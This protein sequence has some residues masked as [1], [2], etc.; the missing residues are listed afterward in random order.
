MNPDFKRSAQMP[1]IGDNQENRNSSLSGNLVEN[2]LSQ[3]QK[4]TGRLSRFFNV[5]FLKKKPLNPAQS[6][7]DD[8]TASF[9]KNT[10]SVFQGAKDMSNNSVVFSQISKLNKSANQG[11]D[12]NMSF[13]KV[14]S[15]YQGNSTK[16]FS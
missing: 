11:D 7:E 16:D 2:T 4:P 8:N 9:G 15:Q 10:K 12:D 13:S 14:N 6:S 1:L 3:P 5:S